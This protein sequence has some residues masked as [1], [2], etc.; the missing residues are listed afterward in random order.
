MLRQRVARARILAPGVGVALVIGAAATFLSEHYTAPVMLFALLL[1]MAFSFLTEA[2]RTNE[3]IEFAAKGLLRIGVALLGLRIGWG[4]I[5]ALGW[6][7]IALLLLLVTGT[8]VISIVLARLMGFNPMFGFLSGG[9]TAICGA[10]AAMALAAALPSHDKK[11]QATLFTVI[12]V[13]VL[14]TLAMV[15]YP[16][17]AEALNLDAREA[18]IFIGATIHDVAQVVGAGYA[19]SPETGDTATLV[20]L[21]R[22]AFLLPVIIVAGQ[23]TRRQAKAEAQRP[24]FLPGFVA[25]FI[26][27]VVLNAVVSLP[28]V[29]VEAG[30]Q[31]SRWCLVAAIAA[32]GMK[33]R[34]ATVAQI[35]IR[36]VILM[37]LETAILA[38]ATLAVLKAGWL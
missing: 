19:V 26:A 6:H 1:G 28:A 23:V 24:P 29:L 31:V 22:V 35:G 7:P 2:E 37:V 32:I 25:A 13:S 38:A 30:N 36:P 21:I 27:L 17:I 5:S 14:S 3:G 33:T 9:A 11:E 16:M 20:K 34:L 12:G 8:I 4:E 15:S 18:G 10:S